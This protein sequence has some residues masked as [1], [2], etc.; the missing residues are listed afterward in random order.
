MRRKC[1]VLYG[2]KKPG[3][4]LL[5][6]LLRHRASI[7]GDTGLIPGQGTK[8]PHAAHS[9]KNRRGKKKPRRAIGALIHMLRK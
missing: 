4:F 1:E 5:V 2:H 3:T 8:I 9:Q 6:Q 7:A